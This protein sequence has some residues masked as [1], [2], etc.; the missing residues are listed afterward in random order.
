MPFTPTVNF[1]N[2]SIT[3][4]DI[5]RYISKNLGEIHEKLTQPQIEINQVPVFVR[6]LTKLQQ[7]LNEQPT[8]TP[9]RQRIKEELEEKTR[10]LI[11]Y[12][13]S[14]QSEIDKLTTYIQPSI[15]NNERNK[16][17]QEHK[18][19]QAAIKVLG[20]RDMFGSLSVFLNTLDLAELSS[21][22]KLLHAACYKQ[23]IPH[24]LMF[25]TT[26]RNPVAFRLPSPAPTLG[27]YNLAR[28]LALQGRNILWPKDLCE[29]IPAQ[30]EKLVLTRISNQ[31]E[32]NNEDDQVKAG[33]TLAR[34]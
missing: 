22:C 32:I 31:I 10:K 28:K 24:K 18:R 25:L 12:A 16:G 29:K 11:G 6:R 19:S 8:N 14:L 33:V 9:E 2:Q 30:L 1:T 3:P 15:R 23:V 7:Q 34:K 4:E 21:V 27:E 13:A 17:E 26:P 5:F 20:S